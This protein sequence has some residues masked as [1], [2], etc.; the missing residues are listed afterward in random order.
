MVFAIHQQE[1]ATGIHVFPP[2]NL[3]C[4]CSF[5]QS[6]PPLCGPMDCSPPG[7]PLHGILQARIL[8]WVAIS[9]SRGSSRPSER[10]SCAHISCSSAL[11]SASLPLGPLKSPIINVL[12]IMK[13]QSE[14]YLRS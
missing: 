4:G 14:K 11:A 7:S 12:I 13:T 10:V 5:A 8:E 2:P 6:C 9:Y 3:M 1:L